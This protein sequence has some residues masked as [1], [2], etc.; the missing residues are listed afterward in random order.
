MMVLQELNVTIPSS[1]F[2]IIMG[3]VASGKSTFCKALVGDVP[4]STGSIAITRRKAAIGYCPQPPY[5]SNGT[6]KTNIIGYS[7]FEQERYDEVL[8]ACN[9]LNDILFL[10][11]GDD[12]VVSSNGIALSRGQR[13]RIALAR[14]LY[15]DCDL[16]ILD[17]VFNGLNPGTAA[18]ILDSVL[19]PERLAHQ[20][21]ITTVL[22]THISQYILRADYVIILGSNGK[23]IQ[24]GHPSEI[25]LE[26]RKT[27]TFAV[28][29]K[30][31]EAIKALNNQAENSAT[32]IGDRL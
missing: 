17:D 6:I 32:P 14:A 8:G 9:S 29:S 11:L 30:A 5:L 16:L 22:S 21:D 13:Q 27:R 24:Q 23:I 1:K 20:R 26:T 31:T 18:Q 12:T 3:P 4:F 2:T 10:P 25:S 28:L 19:G 7:E 15:S